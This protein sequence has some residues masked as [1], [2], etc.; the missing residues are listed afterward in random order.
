MCSI[1]ACNA[2]MNSLLVV[3]WVTG[4]ADLDEMCSG[5]GEARGRSEESQREGG[6][7]LHADDEE[8]RYAEDESGDGGGAPRR[9]NISNRIFK[10][11]KEIR[12]EGLRW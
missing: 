9:R 12:K 4:V 1:L 8:G 2:A 10:K 3:G 6:G 7:V 5:L 11:K